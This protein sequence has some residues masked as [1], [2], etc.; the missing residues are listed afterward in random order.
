MKVLVTGAAGF[1][2]SHVV[3]SLL[4]R[5]YQVRA[6]HLAQDSLYNLRDTKASIELCELDVC[7]TQA[8]NKAMQGVDAVIHLAAIY[9]L[10]MPD[11]SLM[12]DV[13]V[14][15]T[16]K[17]LQ[18][19]KALGVQRVVCTSSIARFGGQGLHVQATEQSPFALA[20][21]KNIYAITKA[22]AHELALQAAAEQDVV[23]CAPTGPIGPGDIGPTP[24]GRLILM[25]ASL[26]AIVS[27]ATVSN[28]ADVRDIAL[29]HVL[30]L[31]K[32][33]RGESYLLGNDDLSAQELAELAMSLQGKKPLAF[34]LP[35][36][37]A[38]YAGKAMGL[39]AEHLTHK[40]PIFTEDSIAIAEL[41]L[42]AD[43]SKAVKELGLPLS[44]LDTAMRDA[45]SWFEEIGY[46]DDKRFLREVIGLRF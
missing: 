21:S 40:A 15:G 6:G 38:K 31:E 33:R 12:R 34:A 1:I 32:G 45:I 14:G 43:C 8:L 11:F 27:P 19:A 44:P 24:T 41:G 26:P 25:A 18:C 36:A 37:L 35:F 7:D 5:G 9:T 2:G 23:L 39:M 20:S 17:V 46:T 28:F 22:E 4:A 13:N 16:R 29:G 30:A 3:R 10:W 42:G